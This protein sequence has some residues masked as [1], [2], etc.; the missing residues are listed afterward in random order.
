M[1][2]IHGLDDKLINCIESSKLLKDMGHNFSFSWMENM[3]F[4]IMVEFAEKNCPSFRTENNDNEN[5]NIIIEF[6]K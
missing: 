5:H 3:I 6:D 1:L 2:I 4:P